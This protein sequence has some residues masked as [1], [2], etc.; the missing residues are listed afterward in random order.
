MQSLSKLDT[1]FYQNLIGKMIKRPQNMDFF[2]KLCKLQFLAKKIFELHL[3]LVHEND[4]PSTKEPIRVFDEK[5]NERIILQD[6]IKFEKLETDD[7]KV[8][9]SNDK[10]AFIK[11]DLEKQLQC[12]I[13]K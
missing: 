8:S 5:P 6:K 2:C 10:E 3:S 4:A 9:T 1:K 7:R 13:C 11:Q 12:K